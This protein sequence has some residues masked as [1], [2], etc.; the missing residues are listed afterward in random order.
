MINQLNYWQEIV[1]FFTSNGNIPC[2][3]ATFMALLLFQLIVSPL[4][5]WLF[6]SKRIE[7]GVSVDNFFQLDVASEFEKN[8][9]LIRYF[10][11]P[12]TSSL[13]KILRVILCFIFLGIHLQLS[14]FSVG[15]STHKV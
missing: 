3:S 6:L 15:S 7:K 5:L 10:A 13:S 1:C 12:K 2:S 11:D 14:R 9:T 8:N 4:L